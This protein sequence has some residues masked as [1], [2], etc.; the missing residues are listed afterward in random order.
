M[1]K[2]ADK[3]DFTSNV[4]FPTFDT[5]AATDQFRA[6]A[7]KGVEQ[8]K[9]AYSKLKS[10]AEQAQKALETS[11][12]TARSATT[13]LSLKALATLRANSEAT[14]SHVEQLLG[15][16]SIAEVIELQAAFVRKGVETGIE[17][18]K[19]FQAAA[20][21]ASEEIGKPVKDVFEKSIRELKVA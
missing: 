15:A 9:E 17:Q 6:F 13:D 19:D 1:A 8:S 11:Y 12:E 21:K 7:E 5:T 18:A 2:T 16:K 10:G 20:S 4:E 14:F 3:T